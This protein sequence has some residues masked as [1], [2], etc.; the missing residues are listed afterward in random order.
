[1][2]DLTVSTNFDKILPVATFVLG[3][4]GKWLQ[5]WIAF[6]RTREREREARRET[7]L[8]DLFERRNAFQRETLLKLQE[9]IAEVLKVASAIWS[10]RMAKLR[11]AGDGAK[12]DFP[13][14]L[15]RPRDAA[16]V[17]VSILY[18]R[19]RDEQVG[20]LIEEFL[21]NVAAAETTRERDA[22]K[23]ATDSC[24]ATQTLV[25]KH[26]GRLLRELDDSLFERSQAAS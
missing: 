15:A 25:N 10:Y 20:K 5:D 2:A 13:A 11:E 12:I 8:D 23:K 16:V 22:I 19:V 3:Y 21:G 4:I 7:R 6:R 1:M 24:F 17:E 18:V 9:A 26:I 14:D